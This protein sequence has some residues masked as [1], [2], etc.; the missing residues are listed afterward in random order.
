MQENSIPSVEVP[1]PS[2]QNMSGDPSKSN[3]TLKSKLPIPFLSEEP[4]RLK[5]F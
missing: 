2:Q 3:Q 4:D 5:Q 1:L